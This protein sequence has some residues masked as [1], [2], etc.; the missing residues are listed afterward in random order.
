M[1]HATSFQ[2]NLGVSGACLSLSR[3]P[4]P[5]VRKDRSERLNPKTSSAVVAL[6]D[7]N[8]GLRRSWSNV[9]LSLGRQL[10]PALP[11]TTLASS[12]F[13]SGKSL[14]SPVTPCL[15]ASRFAPS[16]APL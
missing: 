16:V 10:F 9:A 3:R 15:S 14:R 6:L 7:H 5:G 1:F 11:G 2:L 12:V 4:C 8:A 13:A